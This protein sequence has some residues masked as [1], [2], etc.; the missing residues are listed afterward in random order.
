MKKIAIVLG[1]CSMMSN[2]AMCAVNEKNKNVSWGSDIP[3][4]DYKLDKSHASF[5]FGVD[6]L[7][8]STYTGQFLSFDAELRFDPQKP[9]ASS[10]KASIDVSSLAIPSPPE[11]FLTEMLGPNWFN[12]EKFPEITFVST[13]IKPISDSQAQVRGELTFLG[14][15][16]PLEMAVTFNGGYAGFDP[17]D[18]NARVGFSAEGSLQRSIF[19]MTYGLPPKGSKM[20][21][22]DEVIFR[23]ET[24]FTGP[25]LVTEKP[26]S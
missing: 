2:V 18:P 9:A 17:Y 20:G 25:P 10:L 12:D 19:G 4:G 7:G 22:G 23:I 24:E 15:S 13:S 8:F 6:H 21:V 1:F 26:K 16:L 3:A 11:G 14:K 5:I